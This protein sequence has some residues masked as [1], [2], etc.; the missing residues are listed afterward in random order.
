MLSL[1]GVA[2]FGRIRRTRRCDLV[3]GSVLRV[4]LEVA[5]ACVKPRLSLSQWV[6]E[7]KRPIRCFLVRLPWS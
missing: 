6:T 1:Q 4:G 3:G 2:V 7:K 5:E